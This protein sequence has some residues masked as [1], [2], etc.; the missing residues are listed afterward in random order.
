MIHVFRENEEQ[1]F[2][3]SPRTGEPSS[4]TERGG[5]ESPTL[6]GAH[7][8]AGPTRQDLKLT[9]VC[10]GPV[11]DPDEHGAHGGQSAAALRATHRL[12][13]LPASERCLPSQARGMGG[14]GLLPI[15]HRQPERITRCPQGG[16]ASWAEHPAG[17]SATL[18]LP[19]AGARRESSLQGLG[20]RKWGSGRGKGPARVIGILVSSLR[21][22]REAIPGGR[23]CFLQ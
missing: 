4:G 15:P 3:V 22:H 12:L 5:A 9:A 20:L 14:A 17:H 21:G 16:V 1:L 13:C 6:F 8:H 18:S 7:A 11:D 10:L 2:K 19:V 23:G